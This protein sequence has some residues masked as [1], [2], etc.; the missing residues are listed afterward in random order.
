MD[1]KAARFRFAY[2]MFSDRK[3]IHCDAIAENTVMFPNLFIY[4]RIPLAELAHLNRNVCFGTSRK[5]NGYVLARAT[6]HAAA[7]SHTIH[8]FPD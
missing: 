7:L 6:R 1:G 8:S 4:I 3:Y 5:L 2:F